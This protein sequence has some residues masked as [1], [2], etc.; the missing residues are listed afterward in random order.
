MLSGVG[1]CG[2]CHAGL[3][4]SN[5]NRSA[6]G[7]AVLNA[8]RTRWKFSSLQRHGL[9]ESY[10]ERKAPLMCVPWSLVAKSSNLPFVAKSD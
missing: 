10:F 3:E 5:F 4:R 6:S 9:F 8:F 7:F 2:G 1:L